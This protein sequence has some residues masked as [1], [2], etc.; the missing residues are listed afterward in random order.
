MAPP[1][2]RPVVVHGSTG[3]DGEVEWGCESEMGVY[4]VRMG[5]FVENAEQ[6]PAFGTAG[7]KKGCHITVVCWARDGATRTP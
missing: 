3:G 7:S 4:L 5:E 6:R 2:P 1:F